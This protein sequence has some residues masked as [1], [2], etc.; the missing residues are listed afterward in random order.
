M[1]L[2]H[3]PG[4]KAISVFS[5]HHCM[6]L[7]EMFQTKDGHFEPRTVRTHDT[8]DPVCRPMFD[9]FTF[10]SVFEIYA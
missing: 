9:E 7:V 6:P 4:R 2:G 1:G 3:S 10:M 8:G 5:K